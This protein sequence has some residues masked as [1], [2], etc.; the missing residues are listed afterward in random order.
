MKWQWWERLA[1]GQPACLP[2]AEG[3]QT[4]Q[5]RAELC[6]LGYPSGKAPPH[7]RGPET[8]TV[9][10]PSVG[11][12][13]EGRREEVAE[14]PDTHVRGPWG[15]GLPQDPE[16]AHMCLWATSAGPVHGKEPS[17]G[18]IR[19]KCCLLSPESLSPYSREATTYKWKRNG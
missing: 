9:G 7:P 8:G 14:E 15:P 19:R 18:W 11:G 5:N 13:W 6:H 16:S 2:L 3:P 10:Q 17:C 1:L 4:A 12:S